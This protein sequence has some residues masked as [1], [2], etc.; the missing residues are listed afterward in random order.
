MRS[1]RLIFR[2]AV[3]SVAFV[4]IYLL[5]NEPGVIFISRLGSVAWYPANGL[6]LALLLAISPW[7]AVLV[8]L[9]D[10]MANALV[11]HQPVWSYGGT[12]GAIAV[13]LCYC[14]AAQILRGPL[15][16][17]F[18]LNRGRDVVRYVFVTMTMLVVAALCGV[19]SLVG[20]HSITWNDFWPAAFGWFIGD[21]IGV[22]GVAP[23]LLI[24]VFPWIR[25]WLRLEK[26]E[27]TSSRKYRTQTSSDNPQWEMLEALGQTASVLCVLWIMFGPRWANL[28][29]FYLSFVPI[30]WM[31]MRSGIRLVIIGSLGLNFG[32]VFAMHLFPPQ[33]SL[34]SKIGLLMLVFSASGLIVGAT[35]TE[36][37]HLGMELHERTT[38]L[39]LLFENS[40]L[41]IVVL[42]R[43]ARVDLVND[44]FTRLSHYQPKE[45]IGRDLDSVFLPSDS[46]KTNT[47][48]AHEVL[49]GQ[50]LHRVLQR[51]RKDG[52]PLDLE[53]NAVPLVIDGNVQ[54][55]YAICKDI[56]EQVM[57]SLAEREHAESLNRLVKELE[58]QTDQMSMLNEMASLLECCANT[59]EACTVVGH[60]AEKFFSDATSGTLYT[61]KASRNLVETAV[62]WGTTSVTE[63]V[64]A[65]Q[66][67]WALRR[68]QPHW[69][70]IGGTGVICPHLETLPPAR[71]L[72]LPM[73]G[74]GET[75]GVLHIE[76]PHGKVEVGELH[77]V[78]RLGATVA[79]QI[80]L[81][82]ASLRLRETLRDQSIRDSL[83]GLFNRRFMQESLEREMMRSRRKNHPLSLLFLDIDHFKRFNDT[84]GHDAG[85]FVLQSV[86]DLLRSFFRGDDIACR[87]GGEE[88]A[89]I[90]PESLA[91]HAVVRADAL[92]AEIKKLKLQHKDTRLGPIS[93]SIGVAAFPEHCSTAEELLKVADQCLYQ[94]KSSGRDRVT[95]APETAASA[96]ETTPPA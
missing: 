8:F 72:C 37:Q 91:K 32:I 63:P 31:A 41:G 74:Q 50:P 95:V 10:A 5:L 29:L 53:L 14:T 6:V 88:F 9:A 59:K 11:Y 35:V 80:A 84:F 70:E 67:C 90:L 61:F 13:A 87:C 78:Q 56:S 39:N 30:L 94:S 73:V 15:R 24:H 7:Y 42:N 46:S 34:L 68:G 3:L 26:D 82:L 12:I 81:S 66:S 33:P 71:H 92:R 83:T 85:D 20:D 58:V 25:R 79:G 51:N 23:F 17:D 19:L 38:Y 16:I 43:E 96:H 21:G 54:G 65:P 77:N 18:R 45:L 62:S 76:F 2:H 52:I 47:P 75:L 48:W 49:S 64:F 44:A 60:S 55:A 93:I 27:E 36:R 40:P 86:A 89:I 69:S 28:E 1:K 4:A 22:M 57:A